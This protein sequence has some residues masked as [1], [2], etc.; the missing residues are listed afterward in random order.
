MTRVNSRMTFMT[1]KSSGFYIEPWDQ[2]DL[3]YLVGP[4]DMSA[5]KFCTGLGKKS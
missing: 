2:N 1:V 5:V 4:Y 3:D